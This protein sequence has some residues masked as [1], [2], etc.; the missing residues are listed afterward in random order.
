MTYILGGKLKHKQNPSGLRHES[1]G[2]M[3]LTR[4]C[5]QLARKAGL[6]K[7]SLVQG[8]GTNDMP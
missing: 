2:M 1:D 8:A 3:Q 5:R 6:A 7:L 4:A